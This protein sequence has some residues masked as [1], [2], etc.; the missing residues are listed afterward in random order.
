MMALLIPPPWFVLHE[1]NLRMV[2]SYM[3]CFVMSHSFPP[4][5]CLTAWHPTYAFA[6]PSTKSGIGLAIRLS[7]L[8]SQTDTLASLSRT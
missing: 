4:R 7:N 3:S 8:Q 1:H 6:S 2:S 5:L